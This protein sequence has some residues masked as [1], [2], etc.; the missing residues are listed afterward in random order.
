M[1]E[2]GKNKSLRKQMLLNMMLAKMFDTSH[3]LREMLERAEEE[4]R[5]NDPFRTPEVKQDL[6]VEPKPLKFLSKPGG[7]RFAAIKNK[8]LKREQEAQTSEPEITDAATG[9][10]E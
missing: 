7:E 6:P 3:D 4:R 1:K 5:L 8:A 10:E 9:R 2:D